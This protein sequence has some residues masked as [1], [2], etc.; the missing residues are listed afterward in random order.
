MVERVA[1]ARHQA[2]TETYDRIAHEFTVARCAE[3]DALLVT[4]ASLGTSRL[5]WLSTGPVE[6][7]AVAVRAE[8]DK[9]AFLRGL[10]ADLLDLSALPAERRRFLATMSMII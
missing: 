2:Q 7:S 8:V 5:R 9:L 6:A 1:H 3:L 4:D 10:G